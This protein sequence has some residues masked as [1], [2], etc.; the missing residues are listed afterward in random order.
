MIKL[1]YIFLRRIEMKNY[2]KLSALILAL[3]MALAVLFI[4]CAP[5]DDV[6]ESTEPPVVSDEPSETIAE[7]ELETPEEYTIVSGGEALFRIVRPAE[8]ES[9]DLAVQ[10]ALSIKKFV[11]EK[12]DVSLKLGD[13]WI[14]PGQEHDS[15]AFEILVGYTSYPETAEVA[16]TLSYGEYAVKAIGNKIVIFSYS[17]KGYDKAVGKL[18][19]L[20][21]SAIT[22]EADG[23]KTMK[24]ASSSLDAA[25]T[26]EEMASVLPMYEGGVFSSVTDMGDDCLG[27]VIEET[28]KEQY[29][30]YVK[31]IS[32]GGYE[33]YSTH[34]IVGSHFTILYNNDY[35][36]N[37]GFYNNINEVRVIIEPFEED[38]LPTKKVDAAPVTT[39]QLTMIGVEGIYNGEYQNN[40]LCLI[41]RLS[42]GSFVVVDGGH[43][44]NAAIYATNIVKALREQSKDYTQSYKDIRIAAW[45]ITHPHSD[46]SGTLVKEYKR[47]ADFKVER[48]MT[49]FWPS[50]AFE[51]AKNTFEGFTGNYSSHTNTRSVATALGADYVVPHVGQ[52]WNFGDT[53]FEFLYTIESFLPR[54]AV[55][56]NTSSLV[57]RTSTT[58]ASGK[59]TTTIIPGDATGEALELCTKTF[60]DYLK[61]DIM[62]VTHHGLGNGGSENKI[63]AAYTKMKPSVVLWPLGVHRYN[64][65]SVDYVATFNH[66]LFEKQNP[67]FAEFYLAG[68]Q[69]NSV[70]LPLPYT[71]GTAI[72]NKVTE[73]KN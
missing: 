33:T 55:I 51:T 66:A 70:T 52:V 50:S 42:D 24:I 39:S 40:G 73:N 7:P 49:N 10:A 5:E 18:T 8:L 43:S 57:F 12:T 61:C 13:D 23:T 16:K 41:Y 38:T 58:D 17:E 15:D 27:L 44:S 63:S 2:S 72:I 1:A 37:A 28:T 47:F 3:L 20:L 45:I 32:S 29:D 48:I 59:Q 31:L 67:N 46:H 6:T 9:E 69:G 68:W 65:G 26:V 53:E 56:F 36:I 14:A 21:K 35:T 30:S 71:L 60:G 34:E 64:A 54:V 25:G 11:T 4:G 22:E 19:Y 62:Q